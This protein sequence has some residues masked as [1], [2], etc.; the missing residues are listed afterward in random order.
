MKVVEERTAFDSDPK[1]FRSK[2]AQE[3]GDIIAQLTA[4]REL[5]PR[6]EVPMEIRLKISQVCAE[7][8][9]RPPP[10]ATCVTTAP[11]AAAAF[12][13]GTEMTDED[14]YSVVTLCLRHRLRKDPMATIDE[15]TKVQEVFSRVFGYDEGGVK[16]DSLKIL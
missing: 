14:V 5:L 15:G 4:A 2:Y 8:V 1:T 7:L 3:Q 9:R 12:R 10:A 16:S 6:V 11:R 13:G